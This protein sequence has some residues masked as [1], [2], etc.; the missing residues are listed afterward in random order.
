MADS[1]LAPEK[2]FVFDFVERN[3]KAVATIGDSVFYFG[4][5]MWIQNN[6]KHL[7]NIL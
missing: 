5:L 6:L 2:S 1:N 7:I 4:E 3:A